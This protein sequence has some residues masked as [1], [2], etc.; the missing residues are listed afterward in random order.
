[1]RHDIIQALLLIFSAAAI[2][3][4]TSKKKD[5]QIAGCICG[6]FS[7]P[8][9]MW[10]TWTS[11]QWGM[12]ILSIIVGGSYAK[13]LW[14]RLMTNEFDERHVLKAELLRWAREKKEAET[15]HRPD[16]NIHKRTLVNTWDQMIRRLEEV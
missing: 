7:G 9:W 13:G 6:V 4:V 1:M 15:A 2:W 10:V 11:G 14:Q 8:F 16:E 3:L 5:W 12:F